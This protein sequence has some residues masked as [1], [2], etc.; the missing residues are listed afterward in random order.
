MMRSDR[1]ISNKIHGNVDDYSSG[2]RS[3]QLGHNHGTLDQV[4]LGSSRG[5]CAT[6]V[7]LAAPSNLSVKKGHH[8]AQD[9]HHQLMNHLQYLSKS[10]VHV[11]PAGA[12]GEEH[13]KSETDHHS[14]YDTHKHTL[15]TC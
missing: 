5:I 3:S 9:I 4:F 8:I 6:K 13:H 2:N 15:Y 11:D 12:S 14:D 7:S 10:T 1:H